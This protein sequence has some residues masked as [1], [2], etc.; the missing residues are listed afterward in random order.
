MQI[1]PWNNHIIIFPQTMT[2]KKAGLIKDKDLD[3][4]VISFLPIFPICIN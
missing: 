2:C 3:A 4:S 1:Q